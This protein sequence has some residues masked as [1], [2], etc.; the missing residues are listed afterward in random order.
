MNSGPIGIFDSGLGGLTIWQEIVKI[1]PYE[2]TLYLADHA[3]FPYGER[4]E[5]D[6]RKLTTRALYWLVAKKVKLVVIACNSATVSGLDYYRQQFPEIPIIGV[7][8]VIK[9]AVA[10][11]KTKTIAVLSTPLT[12]QSKYQQWLIKSFALGTKVYSLVSKDL[13]GFVEKG[14]IKGDKV[15]KLLRQD[16][17]THQNKE[18]D[19]LVLGCTHYPFLKQT[20]QRVIGKDMSI[21]DSGGAVAR[22]VDRILTKL[23][24]REGQGDP[25]HSFFTTKD[26]EK[27]TKIS[28]LLLNKNVIFQQA[29]TSG[30]KIVN[31]K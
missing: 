7:V 9:T 31:T 21:I 12:A 15:E 18:I 1:L 3:N 26:K 5:K 10:L 30:T 4:E 20:L 25:C 29:V 23:Q 14:E 19:V 27:V 11:T 8:P 28:R 17:Y 6:I 22:Q 16:I 24:M 2:S 13:V